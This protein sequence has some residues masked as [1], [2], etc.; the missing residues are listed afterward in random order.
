MPVVATGLDA[1]DPRESVDYWR[2]RLVERKYLA[3]RLGWPEFSCRIE[4]DGAGCYFP[5]G[6]LNEVQAAEQ[7][8]EVYRCVVGEGW[9]RRPGSGGS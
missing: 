9:R 2:L 6:T 5:L 8:L 1:D 4:H 7:A 3:G